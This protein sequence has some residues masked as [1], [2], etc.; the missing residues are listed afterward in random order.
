MPDPRYTSEQ[1]PTSKRTVTT[2]RPPTSQ[3][4]PTSKRNPKK[5]RK[6]HLQRLDEAV[7]AAN[8]RMSGPEAAAREAIAKRTAGTKGTRGA[9]IQEIKGAQYGMRTAAFEKSKAIAAEER[10]RVQF[11][12]TNVDSMR[13]I[14]LG[15]SKKPHDVVTKS[16][17]QI[18][19]ALGKLMRAGGLQGGPAAGTEGLIGFY[20][21]C[22]ADDLERLYAQHK[23]KLPKHITL[24]ALRSKRDD[25]ADEFQRNRESINR[26]G[27]SVPP[28]VRRG[29][30]EYAGVLLDARPPEKAGHAQYGSAG[31]M[32]PFTGDFDGFDIL[33]Q[34]GQGQWVSLAEAKKND[35]QG[36][37]AQKYDRIVEK[38][39]GSSTVQVQHGF[40]MAW[41][42]DADARAQIP[43][44]PAAQQALADKY[45][46]VDAG[47]RAKHKPGGEP[48]IDIFPDGHAEATYYDE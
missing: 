10:V 9:A 18:D 36:A 22:A 8:R 12:P 48:L 30:D 45:K 37:L 1:S 43:N 47:V 39:M 5:K 29:R 41:D 13:W 2:K 44:D 34:D 19:T 21:P 6:T 23:D 4:S 31:Y 32:L 46:K 7:R 40:H 33:E 26:L 15:F 38:L 14:R 20:N 28:V 42:P 17:G 25:R 27:A 11:R 16:V 35:P 3:W 24:E